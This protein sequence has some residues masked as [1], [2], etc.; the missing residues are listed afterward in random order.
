M[1]TKLTKLKKKKSKF[2]LHGILT[3]KTLFYF[4]KNYSGVLY[5]FIM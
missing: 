4:T 1:L 3:L 5:N 2:G